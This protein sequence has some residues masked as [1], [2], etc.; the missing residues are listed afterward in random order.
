VPPRKQ[1]V[2]LD[3]RAQEAGSLPLSPSLTDAPTLPH[4]RL[5]R[6]AIKQ[7]ASGRFGVTAHYLSNADELQIK[8]SQGAKPGGS[9]DYVRRLL[10]CHLLPL[11]GKQECAAPAWLVRARLLTSC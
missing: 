9:A 5:G 2:R 4:P 7:I 1:A 8:V 6:S 10:V 3:G 11:Q